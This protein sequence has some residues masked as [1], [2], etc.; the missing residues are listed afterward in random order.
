MSYIPKGCDQQG[1]YPQAAEAATDVGVEDDFEPDY[2][3]M[4][5]DIALGVAIVCVISL[6]VTG[7]ING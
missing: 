5:Q 1:R 6:I 7:L 3:A 4:V 2:A